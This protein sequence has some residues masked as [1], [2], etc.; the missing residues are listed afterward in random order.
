MPSRSD[1]NPSQDNVQLFLDWEDQA[2]LLL[3]L[4]L[5]V[6]QYKKSIAIGMTDHEL[7]IT[8]RLL[9]RANAIIQRLNS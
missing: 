2:I 4:H 5:S 3:G 8:N 9:D 1:L 7:E 6:H